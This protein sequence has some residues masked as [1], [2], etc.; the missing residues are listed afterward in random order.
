MQHANNTLE[1]F[2]KSFIFE[3]TY[4]IISI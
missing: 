3:Y 2:L 1:S 4:S